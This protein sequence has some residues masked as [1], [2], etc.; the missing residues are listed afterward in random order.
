TQLGGV[1]DGDVDRIT[2]ANAMHHFHFEPFSAL[3][4]REACTVGALRA[5]A[6]GHDIAIRST[7]RPGAPAGKGAL[8]SELARAANAGR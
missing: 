5:R 6:V 1:S 7:S 2:H 4:G 3:G 8:A